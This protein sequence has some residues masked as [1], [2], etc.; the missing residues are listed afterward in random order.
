MPMITQPPRLALMAGACAAALLVQPA[1]QASSHR[2]APFITTQPKVDGTDLYMFRSYENGRS[3]YVTLIANYIPLQD[4]YG[5]PNYF[6]MDP[7][8]LY[9]I[10]V[11]NNG[12]A[13]EDISFQFRFKNNLADIAL[14]DRRQEHLDPADPGGGNQCQQQRRLEPEGDFYARRRARRSPGRQSFRG[15]Q[16]GR[17]GSRVHQTGRLHRHEDLRFDRRIRGVCRAVHLHG[18]HPRLQRAGPG[19]RRPAQGSVR[20]QPWPHVRPDQPESARLQRRHRR[21][22]RQE[23]HHARAGSPRVLPD[24]RQ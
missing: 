11:D 8:A 22:G 21:P 7:N 2:E 9:E 16:R 17:W 12:D 19:V 23:R 5:G 3:N 14:P 13:V 4:P 1:A 6:A 18:Q 20:R 24:G 10:H 15:H